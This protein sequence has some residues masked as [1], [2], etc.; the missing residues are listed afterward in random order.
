MLTFDLCLHTHLSY[1]YLFPL[2][3]GTIKRKRVTE[4]RTEHITTINSTDFVS[5][6]IHPKMSIQI[7]PE[8]VRM[9]QENEGV[10]IASFLYFDV[11]DLFPSGKDR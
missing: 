7:P 8:L 1:C 9:F 2:S 10:R 11:K 3:V 4:E 6:E 5:N